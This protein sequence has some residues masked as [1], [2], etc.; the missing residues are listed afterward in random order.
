MIIYFVIIKKMYIYFCSC[1][2]EQHCSSD[3]CISETLVS[4]TALASEKCLFMLPKTTSS[5][6][7]CLLYKDRNCREGANMVKSNYSAISL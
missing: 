4:F 7:V 5:Q 3:R 1:A 6:P 2:L